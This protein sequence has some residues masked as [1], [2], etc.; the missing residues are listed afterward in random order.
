MNYSPEKPCTICKQSLPITEFYLN[1]Y[2]QRH[3]YCKPC[4]KAYRLRSYYAKLNA[5][6][7]G[8]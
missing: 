4:C 7:L 1:K 8:A 3:S 6:M 5:R 2:G